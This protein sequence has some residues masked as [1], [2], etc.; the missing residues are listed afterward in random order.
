MTA[1]DWR[2][3]LLFAAFF[4][5]ALGLCDPVPAADFPGLRIDRERTMDRY[6][7][8]D[9]QARLLKTLKEAACRDALGRRD[10]AATRALLHSGL[11]IGEFLR[12]SVGEALAALKG[13]YLFIPKEHR[14]GHGRINPKT[15]K[16]L[17]AQ[18]HS[19]YLTKPLR[20]AIEDLLKVRAELAAMDCRT[21]DPLV[22]GRGGEGVTVRAFELR[23]KQ[24]ARTAGLAVS[25]PHWL[26]HTYGM[27]LLRHSTAREPLVVAQRALGHRSIAS[28]GV[29]AHATREEL[30]SSLD[31]A[32]Q[33]SAPG[34]VTRA[35][36]R[37][38]WEGR[39]GA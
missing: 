26:R 19:V 17:E 13:G 11:R 30:E 10:D 35:Q 4:F 12:V 23:Y 36:L 33:A 28:T 7:T 21:A 18:D 29:Y 20:R 37:R 31:A 6:L 9:E 34:R 1:R 24:H 39:A 2:D 15:G 27:N 25:S 22:V 3:A 16:A 32:A 5:T 8:G 38:A 14:K